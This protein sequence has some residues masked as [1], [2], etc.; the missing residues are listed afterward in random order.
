MIMPNHHSGSKRYENP[1][2]PTK[3]P[4]SKPDPFHKTKISFQKTEKRKR[5]LPA[6]TPEAAAALLRP[7]FFIMKLAPINRLDIKARMNPF[8]LSS[9]K[10]I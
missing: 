4:Q 9:E 10:P 3:I 6:L 5:F 1:P 7:F 8:R 2:I